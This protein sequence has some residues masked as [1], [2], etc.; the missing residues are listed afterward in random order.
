[1]WSA[2]RLVHSALNKDAVWAFCSWTDGS[3]VNNLISGF[4]Q[5]AAAVIIARLASHKMETEEEFD[6]TR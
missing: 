2:I 5:E 4:D 6:A 3:N 1:M